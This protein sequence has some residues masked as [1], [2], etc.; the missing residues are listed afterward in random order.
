MNTVLQ[1]LED[2]LTHS[3]HGLNAAQIQLRPRHDPGRWNIC[4][5]VQHLLL[6]YTS[7]I[8]SM[9]GRIAKGTPTRSHPAFRQYMA[10]IFV[11]R[12]GLM[13][14]RREAPP[15]VAPPVDPP[16]PLLS[17][18]DLADSVSSEL[19][20]LDSV[21][22]QAEGHFGFTPCSSHFALGALSVQ[23]WRRFHLVHGRHHIRQIVAIR[24]E[25]QL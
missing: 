21:L 18:A 24:R 10:Q 17:G 9:E 15:V 16:D 12:L 1:Q 25:H 20:R 14:G 11:I 7:T 4:Q 5:I 19:A 22:D 13:P 3:L 23:Q 6:T 8:T 2:E